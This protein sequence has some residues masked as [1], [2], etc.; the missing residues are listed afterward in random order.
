MAL[1]SWHLSRCDVDSNSLFSRIL[2]SS[3]RNAFPHH[4]YVV[5]VPLYTRL[6]L[7]R[8]LLTLPWR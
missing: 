4:A 6:P 1:L 7:Y 8:R 2:I 5:L 3:F